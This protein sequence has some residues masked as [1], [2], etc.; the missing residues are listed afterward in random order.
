MSDIV[1]DH[2]EL[3]TV[4]GQQLQFTQ[5]RNVSKRRKDLGLTSHVKEPS[6]TYDVA[7]QCTLEVF[8]GCLGCG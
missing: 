2:T 8:L 5:A 1:H 3:E 4:D 7:L 6:G